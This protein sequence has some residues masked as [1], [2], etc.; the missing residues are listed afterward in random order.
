MRRYLLG[1]I[2][3]E[4]AEQNLGHEIQTG[5]CLT[6][7]TRGDADLTIGHLDNWDSVQARLPADWQPDFLVLYL[8]YTSIPSCLWSAPIPIIGVA[9]DW[10]LLWHHYR[11]VLRRCDLVLTDAAGVEVMR[12]EG[13]LQARAAVLYGYGRDWKEDQES[14]IEDGVSSQRHID[15]LFVGNLHPAVQRER[16][17]WLGRLA[18]LSD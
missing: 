5:N 1:P 10:N 11:S 6:F 16:L 4:F 18:S 13:I 9:A 7:N 17:K 14:R 12:R 15:I 8:P 3:K 2:T